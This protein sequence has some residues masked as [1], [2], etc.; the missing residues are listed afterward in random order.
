MDCADGSDEFH[1]C[2]EKWIHEGDVVKFS[3]QVAEEKKTILLVDEKACQD[4][5]CEVYGKCVGNSVGEANVNNT[6][7]CTRECQDTPACNYWTYNPSDNVCS[8]Y[9]DCA[10]IDKFSCP[11]CI[12]GDRNCSLGKERHLPLGGTFPLTFVCFCL[13]R[14]KCQR[15]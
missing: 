14:T 7:E 10:V 2:K 15:R 1:G 8:L 9:G 11:T 13:Q 6:N 5:K 12:F 3:Y 4:Y